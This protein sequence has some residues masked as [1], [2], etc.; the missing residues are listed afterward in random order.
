MTPGILLSVLMLVGFLRLL[1]LTQVE[2]IA[3]DNIV[4]RPYGDAQQALERIA[5]ENFTTAA[6]LDRL[7]ADPDV[8][9]LQRFV[10][11][12]APIIVES[13]QQS[14]TQGDT[15]IGVY[16]L[17]SQTTGDEITLTTI[18]YFYFS[19]DESG[20][21]LI[22]KRLAL[23]GLPVDR[24]LIYRVTLVDGEV[25]GAHYQAPGH[26]LRS[27]SYDGTQRPMFGVASANNNFRPVWQSEL[28]RREDARLL[29]PLPHNELGADPAHDPDFVALAAREAL[30]EHDV[31]LSEYVYIEFNNPL[32]QGLLTVSARINGRWYYLHDSIAGLTRPGFNRVGIHVGYALHPDDIEEIRLVAYTTGELEIE[33]I[34]IYVYPSLS[35]PA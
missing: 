22:R 9:E 16:Y 13:T 7:A 19:S 12:H 32:P 11:R 10:Y 34:S 2:E 27:L 8:H 24:E 29:A 18:Q 31:N 26:S 3:L 35:L 30:R 15:F 21:T 17:L 28:E 23:F 33:V 1:A 4:T 25:A 20:G 6:E 14:E 5:D